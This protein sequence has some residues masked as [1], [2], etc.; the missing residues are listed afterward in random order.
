[1][2]AHPI[3]R[4][5]P[6]IRTSFPAKSNVIGMLAIVYNGQRCR[7]NPDNDLL[8]LLKRQSFGAEPQPRRTVSNNRIAGVKAIRSVLLQPEYNMHGLAE[9][10][11]RPDR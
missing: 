4:P 9:T 7:V 10:Y 8:S 11:P 2:I 6:V 3:P 5:P 1:M